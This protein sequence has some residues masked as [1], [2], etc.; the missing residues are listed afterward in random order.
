[1]LQPKMVT[2]MKINNAYFIMVSGRLSIHFA[3][4]VLA[5]GFINSKS[6]L[7]GKFQNHRELNNLIPLALEFLYGLLVLF[8]LR[9]IRS[10]HFILRY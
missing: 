3:R 5:Y 6:H 10:H 7:S 9:L 8:Y 4:E 2:K 1:M